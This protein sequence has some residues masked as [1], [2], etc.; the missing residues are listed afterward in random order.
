MNRANTILLAYLAGLSVVANVVQIVG[1]TNDAWKLVTVFFM[2]FVFVLI[3]V[4]REDMRYTFVPVSGLDGQQNI[5]RTFAKMTGEATTISYLGALNTTTAECLID[6]YNNKKTNENIRIDIY[7]T[8]PGF[9]TIESNRSVLDRLVELDALKDDFNHFFCFHPQAINILQASNGH[10]TRTLMGISKLDGSSQAILIN[11][12]IDFHS[13]KSLAEEACP[14]NLS[15]QAFNVE[16]VSGQFHRFVTGLRDGWYQPVFPPTHTRI[17]REQWRDAILHWFD[18]TASGICS[19]AGSGSAV[20]ITWRLVKR[21]LDDAKTFQAWLKMLRKS[22]NIEVERFL[23][24]DFPLYRIDREYKTVVDQVIKDYFSSSP[25]INSHYTVRTLDSTLLK[26]PTL[27]RD[28][29][30]MRI[31]GKSYAQDSIRDTEADV[32]VLRTFFTQNKTTVEHFEQ[33]FTKLA[34]EI[35][36]AGHST[37]VAEG[38]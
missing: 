5:D 20:K 23:L 34:N 27:N 3:W 21:S 18:E 4:Y 31:N 29:A 17:V 2:I 7:N 25:I 26:D 15:Q 16:A 37:P 30:L 12:N 35:P 8:D 33:R 1:S 13:G 22:P 32:E 11:K 38:A 10:R 24:I 14:I 28:F 9:Y 36:H 6:R 19:G